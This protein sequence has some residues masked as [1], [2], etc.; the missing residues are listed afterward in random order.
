MLDDRPTWAFHAV[1]DGTASVVTDTGSLLFEL[2]SGVAGSYVH[3]SLR[4]AGTARV[5]GH[6]QGLVVR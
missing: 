6:G 1:R 2:A 3:H 4:T 5:G